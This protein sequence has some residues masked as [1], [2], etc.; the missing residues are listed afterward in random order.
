MYLKK[1]RKDKK[2]M[3]EYSKAYTFVYFECMLQ[4]LK[5]PLNQ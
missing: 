5:Q 3:K 2:K 1:N 4:T